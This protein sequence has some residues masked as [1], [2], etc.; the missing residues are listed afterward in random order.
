VSYLL[1]LVFGFFT[2]VA[3][4]LVATMDEGGTC[5]ILST[6]SD[7]RYVWA[8]IGLA[9]VT[10]IATGV[11]SFLNP[12]QR[13]QQF[14]AAQLELESN[15]WAFRTRT[16]KY[17]TKGGSSRTAERELHET[18]ATMRSSVLES[19]AV[20]ETDIYAHRPWCRKSVHYR[21]G[22]REGSIPSVRKRGK[23]NKNKIAAS[24]SADL[25]DDHHSIVHPDEYVELRINSAVE[26]Y[27]QRLPTYYCKR[28]VLHILTLVSSGLMVVLGVVGLAPFVAIVSVAAASLTAWGEFHGFPKKLARYSSIINE[29]SALLLWWEH[30]TEVERNGTRKFQELVHH[31]EKCM[32]AERDGWLSTSQA[33]KLLAKELDS[34]NTDPDA[35]EQGRLKGSKGKSQEAAPDMG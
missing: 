6:S 2:A 33:A 11:I 9:L 31:V 15:A 26:F 32:A 25:K 7:C 10:S 3:S 20:A 19:A 29:L 22:Q 4:T 5:K 23:Q 12:V 35:T 18:I 8:V 30:L 27:R 17:L 13:W 16:G 14:R 28:S 1:L 24:A 21:H 34:Q